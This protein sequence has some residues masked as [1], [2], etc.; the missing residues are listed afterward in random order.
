M[1]TGKIVLDLGI[2]VA[3]YA[4]IVCGTCWYAIKSYTQRKRELRF[5]R[6]LSQPWEHPVGRQVHW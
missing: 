2:G 3:A 4:V 6:L 5:Q 1:T